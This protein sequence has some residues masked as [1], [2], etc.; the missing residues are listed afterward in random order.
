MPFRHSCFISYRNHEQSELAERFI[1][2]LCR[3]LRNELSMRTDNDLFVDRDGM[4]GGD[5]VDP[6]LSHALCTSACMVLVYTPLYFNTKKTY[7]A[8]EYLAMEALEL[9]RLTRASKPLAKKFG[10]IFPIILRG[11]LPEEIYKKRHS[12]DFKHFTLLS[13]ALSKDANFEPSIRKLAEEIH[14][15]I[16]MLEASGE[17]LTCDCDS[18]NF[19]TEN[20]IQPWLSSIVSPALPFPNRTR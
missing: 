12:F 13:K 8:R 16:M 20:D 5:F 17:D 6:T 14:L 11:S 18:F 10:L 4:R 7:C 19:P 15:R 2:D 3:A 1:D 9:Q